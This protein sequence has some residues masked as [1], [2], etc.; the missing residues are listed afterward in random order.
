[1]NAILVS[2]H[3]RLRKLETLS[4]YA[5]LPIGIVL[6]E[7]VTDGNISQSRTPDE[8]ERWLFLEATKRFDFLMENKY[9]QDLQGETTSFIPFENVTD[10]VTDSNWRLFPIENE[11]TETKGFFLKEVM[12]HDYYS[13]KLSLQNDQEH[14]ITKNITVE[15]KLFNNTVTPALNELTVWQQLGSRHK[16]K[17]RHFVIGFN[18][19]EFQQFRDMQRRNTR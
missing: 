2:L 19:N 14:Y 8:W 13:L 10:T 9:F 7:I 1:M 11:N 3:N 16:M 15:Y 17:F 5:E 12:R 4:T 18:D 6:K